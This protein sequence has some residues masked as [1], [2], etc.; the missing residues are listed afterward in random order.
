MKPWASL[1]LAVVA[2]ASG[3]SKNTVP[4]EIVDAAPPPAPAASA[5]P[6][7]THRHRDPP[8]I[9]S[10]ANVPPQPSSQPTWALDPAD[11]AH[12]YVARYLRATFR[13]G[14]QTG[15]VVVGPSQFKDGNTTVEVT[16]GPTG[17]CG[18]ANV[19]RETFLVNV[20]SDRL[21]V[22][23][24]PDHDALKKWPDG[25]DPE[26]PAGPPVEKDPRSWKSP[27][28]DAIIGLNL[29]PVR[30][31]FYGRGTY[32]IVTIA[33]WHDQVTREATPD[34]LS[35]IARKLCAVNENQGFAIF[36]GIDRANMLRI[37]CPDRFRW[38]RL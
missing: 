9:P 19:S 12:E 8:P 21:S 10:G 15:C 35:S 24:P 28:H 2:L 11:P 16:N 1:P 38:D 7:P 4:A 6:G 25:S 18:P 3:C 36:A 37:D 33:G 29:V 31:Q 34:T 26:G 17:S 14:P 22:T 30:L 27:L 23:A 5:P 32:P 13:Y 20:S